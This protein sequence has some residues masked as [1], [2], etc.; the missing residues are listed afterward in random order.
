MKVPLAVR[1]Y[2]LGET[3]IA[4]VIFL[5]HSITLPHNRNVTPPTLNCPEADSVADARS[6]GCARKDVRC[7]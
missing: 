3:K 5:E 1:V 7:R 2:P 4:A 6:T